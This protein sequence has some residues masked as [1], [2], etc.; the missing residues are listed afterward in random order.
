MR[1]E[2]VEELALTLQAI[3][4]P[5]KTDQ[6]FFSTLIKETT[7]LYSK[8]FLLIACSVSLNAGLF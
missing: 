2:E 3:W 4:A 7:A 1:R 6:S 5:V 8:A